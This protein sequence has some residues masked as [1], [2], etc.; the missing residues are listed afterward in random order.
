MIVDDIHKHVSKFASY[1]KICTLLEHNNHW[2]DDINAYLKSL[3]DSCTHS[4]SAARPRISR[5]VLLA[6]LNRHFN[7][8][9]C[10]D[11]LFSHSIVFLQTKDAATR[12]CAAAI[13]DSTSHGHS[14]FALV[15]SWAS[16]FWALSSVLGDQAFNKD[17][18][19]DYQSRMHIKSKPIRARRHKKD[20]AER[21]HN[22]IRSVVLRP[23]RPDSGDYIDPCLPPL[24]RLAFR[25]IYMDQRP[26]RPMR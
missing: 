1:A 11:H 12:Y 20:V 7:Q 8:P 14:V 3:I 18:F 10:V 22:I 6:A 26:F 2:Y 9:V 21:E 24:P 13:G 15:P 25:M 17:D 19:K 23:K 4:Q 16:L 5:K